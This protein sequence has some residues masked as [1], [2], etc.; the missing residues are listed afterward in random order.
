MVDSDL[1]EII[2]RRIFTLNEAVMNREYGAGPSWF[3]DSFPVALG[4]R[5]KELEHP[6]FAVS[7]EAF[8]IRNANKTINW[9]RVPMAPVKEQER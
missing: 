9:R 8:A 3:K 7:V 4:C 2:L 5:V 1:S 6:D